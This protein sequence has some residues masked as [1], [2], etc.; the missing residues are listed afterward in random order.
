MVMSTLATVAGELQR[1]GNPASGALPLLAQMVNEVAA[2]QAY[3]DTFVLAAI[4]LAVATPLALL[5]GGRRPMRA[6]ATVTPSLEAFTAVEDPRPV[7]R[8]YLRPAV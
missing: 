5:L 7:S 1:H 8:R 4:V 2:V 3:G 6:A